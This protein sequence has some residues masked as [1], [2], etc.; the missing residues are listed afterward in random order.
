MTEMTKEAF[1]QLQDELE[2]F[3]ARHCE[4][5]RDGQHRL[6]PQRTGELNGECS[7]DFDSW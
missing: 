4:R 3:G 6:S 5:R 7:L 1:L 2:G